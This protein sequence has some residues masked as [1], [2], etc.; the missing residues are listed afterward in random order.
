M[1]PELEFRLLVAQHRERIQAAA[2]E[3]LADELATQAAPRTGVLD[4]L[5]HLLWRPS[6]PRAVKGAV[7]VATLGQ[8]D[9]QSYEVVEPEKDTDDVTKITIKIPGT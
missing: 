8:G 6:L 2:A 3:H 4:H 1:S 9:L 5:R 7:K